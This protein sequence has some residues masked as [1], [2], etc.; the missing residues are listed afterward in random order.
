MNLSPE[1][2]FRAGNVVLAGRPNV[3]KSS[4]VNRLLE[5][6]VS[7][8]SEKPQTTRNLIRCIYNGEGFQIV[9]TDTPGI[10]LPK[11]TLGKAL[12]EAAVEA[13]EDACLVCYVVEA[14]DREIGPEDEEIIAVLQ[15][16][17]TPVLLV[18]NKCDQLLQRKTRNPAGGE[19]ALAAVGRLYRQ[20]LSFCGEIF[21][22]ARTG[23]GLDALLAAIRPHLPEG[24]PFYDEDILVDRPE[25]F[26]ASEMIREKVLRLTHRE[27]PHSVA[28]EIEEYKSPD[29]YPERDVLF[30]RATLY[31]E[32]EG[33]KRIV[34]GDGGARLKEIGRLA[35]ID[36]E[37]LTGH[38]VYLELWI[39]VR[40]DWRRSESD[41]RMLGIRERRS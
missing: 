33:Q 21:V 6:K 1:T 12:V 39:K 4:L 41:L 18:V 10:H 26:I 8:V 30:I 5:Y 19:G 29:E 16:I 15:K 35:R 32:R 28:V 24:P 31:V 36:I 37:A 40:S 38:K 25:K 17:R 14:E 20:R 3:G 34:I 22:S 11:H 7:I 9:F 13:L 23:K 2:L 27:V